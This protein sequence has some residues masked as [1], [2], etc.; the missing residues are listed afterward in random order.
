MGDIFKKMTETRK[1]RITITELK[2][3]K[4]EKDIENEKLEE[5]LMKKPEAKKEIEPIIE[6]TQKQIKPIEQT[7]PK[8]TEQPKRIIDKRKH[9]NNGK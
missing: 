7:I 2:L 1:S 5:M 4:S 8:K 3:E 9:E 6:K